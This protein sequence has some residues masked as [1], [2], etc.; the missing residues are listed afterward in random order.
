MSWRKYFKEYGTETGQRSPVGSTAPA[1]GAA[2]NT[3]YNTWLPEVYA[4]QPNRR[5]RYYQYDMMDLDTEINA[6]LDTIA[7][8]SSPVD[9]KSGS[10]FSIHYNSDPTDTESGILTQAL[11]QWNKINK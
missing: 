1:S 4:G 7:E 5:E 3:R 9:E 11:N 2:S 8:F 10:P 6:A